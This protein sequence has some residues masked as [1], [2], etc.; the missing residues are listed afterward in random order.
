VTNAATL[1]HLVEPGGPRAE[2]AFARLAGRFRVVVLDARESPATLVRTLDGA[3]LGAFNL[4]ASGGASR[5][6]PALAREAGARLL[7]LA[8]ESPEAPGTE[9]APAVPTLVLLGTRD[10]EP[11]RAAG[12]G[13]TERAPGAHL[14]YVYDAGHAI[15]DERP[16]AFAD[17][18][19]DFFERHE[20]FVISRATTVIYP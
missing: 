7:A 18:V 6:V 8:L 13:W 2:A 20:A 15:S 11:A 16:D 3:G 9:E 17:V 14:V 10:D 5:A 19:G 4:L 1:A 12:R